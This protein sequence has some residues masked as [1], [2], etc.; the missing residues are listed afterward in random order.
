MPFP[1][2]HPVAVFPLRRFCPSYLSLPAL[3]AGSLAPDVAYISGDKGLSD[4][5]HELLGGMCFGLIVGLLMLWVFYGPGRKGV[6]LLPSPYRE[7]LLPIFQQPPGTATT[8]VISLLIGTGTHLL[9]DSFTHSHG[10]LV[11]HLS[12]L[13]SPV[14]KFMGRQVKLCHLLWYACSFV[15]VAWLVFALRDF[16]A[17]HK[18]DYQHPISARSRLLEAVFVS[19]LVLPI[20]LLHHVVR[21]RLGLAVVGAL[22]LAL[23]AGVLC[24]VPGTRRSPDPQPVL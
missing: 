1:L 6:N 22:T 19:A 9:L 23:V 24:R 4:V 3:I 16:Q 17:N 7:R 15:G 14:F 13:Q 18:T 5:S 11:L 21:S 20:E 2:A 8:V 12:V 10:W